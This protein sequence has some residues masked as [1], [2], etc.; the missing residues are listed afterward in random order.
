MFQACKGGREGGG[1]SLRNGNGLRS[2]WSAV[3]GKREGSMGCNSGLSP[4][5]IKKYS[6]TMVEHVG[7]WP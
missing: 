4:D 6:C 5:Q 3:I 7:L 2:M 1:F